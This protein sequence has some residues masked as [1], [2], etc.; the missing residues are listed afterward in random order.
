MF[1]KVAEMLILGVI[2]GAFSAWLALHDL[3]NSFDEY[4]AADRIQHQET[5]K[6]LSEIDRCLRERTCTK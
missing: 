3:K 5:N 2:S 4:V 1:T 6:K